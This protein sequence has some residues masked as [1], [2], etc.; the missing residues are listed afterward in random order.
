MWLISW[1]LA[2]S[3]W[4]LAVGSWQLAVGNWQLAGFSKK[5]FD[6]LTI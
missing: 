4:Q 1:Q 2:I 5:Q 6:N 3:S